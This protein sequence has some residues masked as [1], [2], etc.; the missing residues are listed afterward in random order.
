MKPTIPY[1]TELYEQMKF[2]ADET[3]APAMSKYMKNHFPYLG[4]KS[5]LQKSICK[6]FIAEMGV[7]TYSD[8]EPVVKELWN[9]PEREMQYC[10]IELVHRNKKQWENSI[11]A[12]AEYMIITKSWWDTTDSI[13]SGIIGEY[14][15]EK[16][17]KEIS[18]YA[19]TLMSSGNMWLQRTSIIFQRKYKDKTDEKLL[20]ALCLKMIDSKEFF[21]RK[22]MGWALREYAY[23]QPEKVRSF[24]LAHPF[25]PLTQR[26][27][28]KHIGR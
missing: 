15:I 24:V 14:L 3:N 5:P 28:L 7:P 18:K 17:A 13:S 20:F 22:G 27:A 11:L 25:S 12:L 21:I 16:E 19:E 1:V 4:I 23:R 8:L 2:H 26:E 9:L 10:A 6:E